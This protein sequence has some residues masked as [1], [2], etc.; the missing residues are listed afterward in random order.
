MYILLLLGGMFCIASPLTYPHN[1]HLQIQTAMDLKYWGRGLQKVPK[2]KTWIFYVPA[3]IYIT[4]IISNLEM[5]YWIEENAFRLYANNMSFHVRDLSI[6]GFWYPESNSPTDTKEQLD[7]SFKYI[8][9]SLVFLYWFFLCL[10]KQS[11][12]CLKVG[13][14]SLS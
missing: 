8:W 4:F 7:I 12:Y 11:T 3:T 13:Y 6:W 1:L 14:G 2:G 9:L 5:L 10:F